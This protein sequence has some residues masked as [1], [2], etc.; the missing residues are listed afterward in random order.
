[1]VQRA[2]WFLA[3]QVGTNADERGCFRDALAV[4]QTSPHALRTEP[5]A[6]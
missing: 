5:E 1:M 2:S 4:A 6:H 3:V